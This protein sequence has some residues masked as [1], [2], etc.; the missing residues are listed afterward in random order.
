[1]NHRIDLKLKIISLTKKIYNIFKEQVFVVKI[2]INEIL[3]KKFIKSSIFDY[4]ALVFIVKK[5]DEELKICVDYRVLNALIIKNRIISSLIR[6][7]LARLYHAKI[8]S[9]FDII[10]I[11]NK[12]RMR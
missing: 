2:Y 10:A 11:F 4:V 1:M 3:N 7:I 12:I 8:Y 9:K 6:D 5:L